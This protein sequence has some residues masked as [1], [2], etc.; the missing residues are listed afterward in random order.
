[1]T[2]TLKAG[3]VDMAHAQ[4]L[5]LEVADAQAAD[6]HLAQRRR[7]QPPVRVGDGRPVGHVHGDHDPAPHR[8][9]VR[10]EQ[11]QRGCTVAV[12]RDSLP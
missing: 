5:D 11:S 9:G 4:P 6:P 12:R 2:G 7:V 3:L 1:M 10:R 8:P